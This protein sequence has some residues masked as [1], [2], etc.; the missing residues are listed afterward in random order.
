V[1]VKTEDICYEIKSENDVFILDL[2]SYQDKGKGSSR[3]R[4]AFDN[5]GTGFLSDPKTPDFSPFKFYRFKLLKEFK[6]HEVSFLLPPSGENLLSILLTNKDAREIAGNVFSEHGFKVVLESNENKIKIQKDFEGVI[7]IVS[8]Y[9]YSLASDTLQRIVFYLA[10]IDTNKN[11]ILIFEE[12]EVHSFP[13]YT[14]FLGERIALNESNQYFITTH[15]PY[16]LFSI[17]GKVH[18]N[19]IAIFVTYFENYQTRAKLLT[20]Q[21]LTKVFDLN[22]SV[23]FNLSKFVE[24]E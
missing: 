4:H 17:L 21:D 7:G 20:Q 8:S 14:K 2:V 5:N 1:E 9:P 18:K 6:R 24:E 15:N 10:A 19:E 3:F 23:F 16:L 22:S 11:S 13:Y 12:P